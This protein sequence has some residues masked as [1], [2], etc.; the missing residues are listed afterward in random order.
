MVG[1][2]AVGAFDG[3]DVADAGASDGDGG[4]TDEEE[5]DKAAAAGWMGARSDW[6][7]LRRV[8]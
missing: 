5:Q 6:V 2:G 3:L 4:G 8:C 1:L 7:L